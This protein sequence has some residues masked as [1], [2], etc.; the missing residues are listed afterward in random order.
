LRR[1]LLGQTWEDLLFAHW[2]VAPSALAPLVPPGLEIDTFD[3]DAWLGILPFRLTGFRLRGLPAVPRFSTFPE[4]N[5]RT[6]V[7]A[8]GK[9][10]I[11]FL[12]LDAGREWAV[13]A[14]RRFYKLP[15][16]RAR[17]AMRGRAAIEFSSERASDGG[18]PQRSFQARY[19]PDGEPFL[20]APGTLEYFLT[21]RYCLYTADGGRI[22]R[23]EAHHLP[24]WIQP[25][26]AELDENTMVPSPLE[27][28]SQ[29][30]LLHYSLRQDVL[31]WPL[32]PADAEDTAQADAAKS[33]SASRM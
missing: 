23:A 17:M 12:S 6:Y 9:P 24:W 5:V 16:F 28:P 1:W 10:G 31:V 21:E 14:A 32:Q 25:A 26:Q 22:L 33:D 4:L 13:T 7:T 29:G 11:Y 18:Q 19:R 30:P 20:A 2:P 3:G 8:G 27:L 15:Y